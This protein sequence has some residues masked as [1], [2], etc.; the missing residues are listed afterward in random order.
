MKIAKTLSGKKQSE[1]TKIKRI[2]SRK[3]NKMKDK[4]DDNS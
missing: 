3:N 1:E 4:N 2:E